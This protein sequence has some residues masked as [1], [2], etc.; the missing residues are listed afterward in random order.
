M[1]A[2]AR[3]W[4]SLLLPSI[5][6][7]ETELLLLGVDALADPIHALLKGKQSTENI[8]RVRGFWNCVYPCDKYSADGAKRHRTRERDNE[9]GGGRAAAG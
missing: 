7:I 2:H 8:T 3:A 9:G 5:R 6:R 1:C 4:V